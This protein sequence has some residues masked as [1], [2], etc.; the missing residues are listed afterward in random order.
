MWGFKCD[1]VD[2]VAGHAS[3]AGWVRRECPQLWVQ[4]IRLRIRTGQG[5]VIRRTGRV[6]IS[7]D[8]EGTVWV[9][10]ATTTCISGSV[11]L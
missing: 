2:Y 5:T 10:G 7:R 4:G 11:D 3:S 6:H 1:K 8:A 9:G